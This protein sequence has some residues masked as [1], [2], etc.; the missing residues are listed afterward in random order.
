LND[1][2]ELDACVLAKTNMGWLWHRLLAY[3]G[4]K[5][6]H[7]LLKG[8]HV[9]GVTNVCF[10]KDKPCAAY[11]AG[12]RVGT[13]HHPKNLMTTSRPLELLHM[14]LF[15]LVSYLRIGG[16]KYGIVIVDDFTRFTLVFFL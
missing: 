10:E 4:M 8:E 1:N 12:K 14:D 5:I 13:S 11:Q 9:L 2:I 6:L 15:G 16:S 7:K 3:V